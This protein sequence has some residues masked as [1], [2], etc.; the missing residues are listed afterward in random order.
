MSTVSFW[1]RVRLLAASVGPGIFMIGYII[2]TGSVTAMSSAGSR[3][4]MTLA[5]T[6]ILA[7][8]FNH[9]M[10]VALSRLTILS[11]ET[12]L[13]SFRKGFGAPITLFLIVG[14]AGTQLTSIIGVMAIVADVVRQWSLQV[15][16]TAIPTLAT[17]ITITGVL[18]G[19]FWVGRHQFFLR[20]L[21]AMV[22]V[23]G[24]A[25]VFTAIKVTPDAGTML[26][27]IIPSIPVG[28]NPE[29]LLASMIGT[30]MASVVLFTRAIL[31]QEKGW[32]M[33]DYHEVVRDSAVANTLLFFLN[34][35]IMA[36]AAGTLYLDGTPVALA[37]DM[38]RS[39]EPL[40][41]NVAVAGFSLGIVAAG[42]SSL[43][44]NY[45]LGPW[46]A[47]DFSGIKRDMTKPSYRLMVVGAASLGLVVPI[48]GGRP[49]PLMIASQAV[50]PLV[51]PLMAVFVWILVNKT[52]FVGDRK[53]SALLNLCLGVT[54]LFTLYAAYL[55]VTGFYGS[56]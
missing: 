20:A 24:G 6:L 12:T 46:L 48:F 14:M 49:V 39:L 50:S 29:L 53:P 51:M 25:F 47:S 36:C 13:R 35:S 21:A 10:V 26:S 8:L 5:W 28:D 3:Y 31:V 38:V 2:G 22:A 15:L 7:S 23:M 32:T 43:F 40:A 9:I 37:I 19:L 45:L 52:S 41:G 44:P 54:V 16:G 56:L 34:A 1:R 4:G 33:A 18:L 27:G 30:T 42:M 17:A 11:G 55:A